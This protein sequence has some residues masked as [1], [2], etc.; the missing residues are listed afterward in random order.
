MNINPKGFIICKNVNCS[1]YCKSQ[2]NVYLNRL[3]GFP[4]P[5]PCGKQSYIYKY[6]NAP[7][8]VVLG[9]GAVN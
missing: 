9:G 1:Y 7:S 5:V 3:Q 8:E 2:I 6:Q 4:E